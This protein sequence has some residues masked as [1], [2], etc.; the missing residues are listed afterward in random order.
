M[1]QSLLLLPVLPRHTNKAANRHKSWMIFVANTHSLC[2]LGHIRR[3]ASRPNRGISV[4]AQQAVEPE[5][6]GA[7]AVAV[8]AVF[9]DWA[10]MTASAQR[11]IAAALIYRIL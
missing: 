1:Y 9:D 3:T 11:Y 5:G 4:A 8:T 6:R 2:S 7:V 10:I